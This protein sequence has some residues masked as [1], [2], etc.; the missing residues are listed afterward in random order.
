MIQ[1]MDDVFCGTMIGWDSYI[2]DYIL[3]TNKVHVN[4]FVCLP[5]LLDRKGGLEHRFSGWPPLVGYIHLC[6][7]LSFVSLVRE[8]PCQFQTRLKSPEK[9]SLLGNLQESFI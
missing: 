1:I 3:L 7:S 9:S 4:G 8:D 6:L 2:S 5:V